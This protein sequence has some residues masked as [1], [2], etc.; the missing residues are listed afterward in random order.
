MFVGVST[1]GSGWTFLQSRD[2]KF[3]DVKHVDSKDV[4]FNELF[5]DMKMPLNKTSENGNF[6]EPGLSDSTIGQKQFQPFQ[7]S[8]GTSESPLPAPISTNFDNVSEF[9]DALG[10][11]I[12]DQV[13]PSASPGATSGGGWFFSAFL[14]QCRTRLSSDDTD[15][16]TSQFFK[17]FKSSSVQDSE[18]TRP[19]THRPQRAPMACPW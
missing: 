2:R 15:D 19:T 18:A 9:M 12:P 10:I 8:G 1:V 4:K 13:P 7:D 17:L 16:S 6:F 14:A 5:E 11:G 3:Y